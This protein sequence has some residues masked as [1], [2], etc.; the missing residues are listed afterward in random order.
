MGR[1]ALYY[2]LSSLIWSISISVYTFPTVELVEFGEGFF[3][4]G[5]ALLAGLIMILG[6]YDR[7]K[8]Q[9]I[10]TPGGKERH[11]S[12]FLLAL[13]ILVLAITF[14]EILRPV[15]N[16]PSLNSALGSTSVLTDVGLTLISISLIAI[17]RLKFPKKLLYL[18]AGVVFVIGF[19]ILFGYFAV[20]YLTPLDAFLPG[21]GTMLEAAKGLL[22]ASL[23]VLVAMQRGLKAWFA[24][25]ILGMTILFIAIL[26]LF[27]QYYLR[28]PVF[29]SNSVAFCFILIGMVQL[30][31]ALKVR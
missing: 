16:S 8:I 18:L 1:T 7:A 12:R 28:H 11:E 22:F 29:L 15:I 5:L 2:S 25:I 21:G 10:L 6:A 27:A 19:V 14:A 13:C 26:D 24:K 30:W 20:N 9:S 31:S 17:I 23:G 3:F 4:L